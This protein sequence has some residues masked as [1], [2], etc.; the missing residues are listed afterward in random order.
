MS[1]K[2]LLANL[3]ASVGLSTAATATAASVASGKPGMSADDQ[4]AGT[5]SLEKLVEAAHAEGR[6]AGIAEGRKAERERFGAVLTD[7]A[8]A[9]RMGL[10]ITQLS[11]TDNTPEQIIGCL[12]ASPSAAETVSSAPAPAG[13]QAPAGQREAADPLAGRDPIAAETAIVAP[14]TAAATGDAPDEKEL[15]T[16]WSGAIASASG[17]G[18]TEGPWAGVFGNGGQAQAN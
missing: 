13:Q 3:L 14:G 1:G 17:G 9:G 6:N 18:L 16:F 7:E 12:K 10:A 8:A 11:T 5:E 15:A 4:T 2:T